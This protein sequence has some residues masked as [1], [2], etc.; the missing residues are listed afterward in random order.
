[1]TFLLLRHIKC[2]KISTLRDAV[3]CQ[4]EAISIEIIRNTFDGLE[5]A[6]R[7]YLHHNCVLA[8]PQNLCA[9]A[10]IC[11][12]ALQEAT[13]SSSLHPG[14][15]GNAENCI[16]CIIASLYRNGTWHDSKTA[17]TRQRLFSSEYGNRLSLYY[18]LAIPTSL[19]LLLL[20]LF[21]FLF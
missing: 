10:Y 6:T 8:P 13:S 17:Q 2:T 11:R 3:V 5:R 12:N 4:H 21:L 15:Q 18:S 14:G 7:E 20:F 9:T 16:S 19:L 1:M